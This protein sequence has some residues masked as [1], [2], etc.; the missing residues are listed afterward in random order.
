LQSRQQYAVFG[1]QDGYLNSARYLM[2]GNILVTGGAGY[3]GS[4]ACKALSDA[5]YMPV[6]YDD[7]CLGNRWAVKWGPL[8]EANL[9]NKATL[10]D[11]MQEYDIQAVMHFA[12]YSDVGDSVLDPARYFSNNVALSLNVFDAMLENRVKHLVISSTCAVYGIPDKSPITENTP[13]API[14][15]YG[16]SKAMMEDIAKSYGHAYGF[17]SIA[18]RYFNAAGAD[19]ES[20]IG[21]CHVPETHLIPIVVA[22][23]LGERSHIKINGTDYDTPDGTAIRDYIHV[24]DL[25]TAHVA[26]LNRLMNGGDSVAL[27]LGSGI[28]HS[29]RDIINAV[30]DA[31]G[32]SPVIREGPRRVGD[33]PILVADPRKAKI[34]LD[35]EARVSDLQTIAESAVQWH[36]DILPELS[37]AAE[38][39]SG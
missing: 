6:A 12:A 27:N 22:A 5:G 37:R 24:R 30:R 20:G 2:L 15:P 21:E 1:A 33:A 17:E 4:H 10:S 25:A 9:K 23:A 34:K 36:R 7:L 29:I 11:T 39:V 32:N 13:I 35:W 19:I 31:T 28:G 16:L 14:N 26:A 8:V 18:L 3:V 38:A